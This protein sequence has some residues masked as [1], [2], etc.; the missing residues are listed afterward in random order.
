MA[1]DPLMNELGQVVVEEKVPVISHGRGS[2]AWIIEAAKKYGCITMP[3]VGAVRHA[4]RAERDGADIIV[5][6]GMEGAGHTSYVSTMVL[7][8]LVASRVKVPVLA[9]GGF[10]DGRSLAAALAL[11]ADGIYMGTRFT[12]TQESPIHEAAKQAYIRASEEDTVL[13]PFVTG[14]RARG[15]KNKLGDLAERGGQK[16]SIAQTI[17]YTLELSRSFKV[18]FWKVLSSGLKMK[19]LG[20]VSWGDLGYIPAGVAKLKEGLL[21]GDVDWGWFPSGQVCGRIADIPTCKELIEGIMEEAKRVSEEVRER[22]YAA[23]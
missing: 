23:V 9:A 12:V 7:L 2:A 16:I 21:D 3:T 15:L 18:P 6:Q 10:C 11:G 19:K 20:N 1:G 14:T 22:L 8:P 5:V 4:L 17:R 13:T